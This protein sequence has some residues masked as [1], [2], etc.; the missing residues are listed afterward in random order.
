MIPTF[1]FIRR[2]FCSTNAIQP[3]TT[4][5]TIAATECLAT[6]IVGRPDKSREFFGEGEN[7]KLTPRRRDAKMNLRQEMLRIFATDINQ[8]HTDEDN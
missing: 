7:A 1:Q 6:S 2:I 4:T 3:Q 8:M 5:A